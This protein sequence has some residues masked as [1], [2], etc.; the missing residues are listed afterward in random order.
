MFGQ[1]WLYGPNSPG[2]KPEAQHSIARHGSLMF[3]RESWGDVPSI[4]QGFFFSLGKKIL[5]GSE[6]SGFRKYRKYRL[7]YR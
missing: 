3:S 4:D 6:K 7:K 5:V 2:W 1:P